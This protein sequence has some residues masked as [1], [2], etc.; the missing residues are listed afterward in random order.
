MNATISYTAP[1][2][3]ANG[4]MAA[5]IDVYDESGVL[6]D[7]YPGV[8]ATTTFG[9]VTSGKST[10][11]IAD[12]GYAQ[13]EDLTFKIRNES[14]ANVKVLY[15]T[16]AGKTA[17][18]VTVS[19]GATSLT[20]DSTAPATLSFTVSNT[21]YDAGTVAYTTSGLTGTA[22]G[23][24]TIG[25]GEN[26]T[27]AYATGNDYA[28]V[29]FTG[30]LTAKVPTYSVTIDDTTGK[31]LTTGV[32][33]SAFGVSTDYD[34]TATLKIAQTSGASNKVSG[35]VYDATDLKVTITE[36]SDTARPFTKAYGYVVTIAG[37]GSTTVIDKDE[38]A[39]A[40]L[41]GSTYTITAD[42]EITVDDITV[43]PIKK[44]AVVAASTSWTANS[45]TITFNE[46]V[47]VG[48][49]MSPANAA[50]RTNYAWAHGTGT[51]TSSTNP[52]SVEVVNSKTV[53]LNF[54]GDPLQAG[55]KITLT[56]A[57]RPEGS[58]LGL[59]QGTV[60]NAIPADKVIT[61][62]ANGAVTVART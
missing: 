33:L 56:S 46:D 31:D 25:T 1:D 41:A 24:A 13:G 43:T 55:N 39:T 19:A 17:S 45:V 47:A 53:K 2:Y 26:V 61:L 29:I 22:D 32:A 8:G 6:L 42:K 9:N 57:S 40:L 54:T 52:I 49:E 35:Y 36:T 12:T 60:A 30:T 5:V 4:T 38:T 34:S 59:V 14:F 50:Q 20:T 37:F 21:A 11:T 7:T 27:G 48:T 62:G 28:R 23:T 51:N 10:I 3:V 16:A 15:V 44:L 18:D 58:V